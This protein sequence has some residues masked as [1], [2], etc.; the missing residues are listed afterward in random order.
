MLSETVRTEQMPVAHSQY[1]EG[2][3]GTYSETIYVHRK[4]H[5]RS[6]MAWLGWASKPS[7]CHHRPRPAIILPPPLKR[8]EMEFHRFGFLQGSLRVKLDGAPRGTS[9]GGESIRLIHRDVL[10]PTANRFQGENPARWLHYLLDEDT[11]FL[12]GIGELPYRKKSAEGVEEV[13][14]RGESLALVTDQ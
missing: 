1:S 7:D 14:G 4:L 6:L 3:L 5:L 9:A 8:H 12:F 13:L 11:M 10:S 2:K